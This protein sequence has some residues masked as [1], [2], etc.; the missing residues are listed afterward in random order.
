MLVILRRSLQTIFFLFLVYVIWVTKDP[1]DFFVN[2]SYYFKLDPFVMFITSIAERLVL[3]GIALALL[4]IV[5]TAIFGRFFCGWFCPL[6]AVMDFWAWILKAFKFRKFREG[7]PSKSV[8]VK[9]VILGVV[10][11]FSFIGIQIA[12]ALD[13]IAVFVRTFSFDF[14]PWVNSLVNAAFA[15]SMV[16]LGYPAWLDSAFNWLDQTILSAKVPVFP[17]SFAILALFVFILATVLIKRRF[18]C[19]YVCPLGGLLAVFAKLA[20]YKRVVRSCRENC[21]LCSQVCRM[22]AITESNTYI[23]QECILCM[24]CTRLCPNQDSSFSFRPAEA[25]VEGP[26]PDKMS[27]ISRFDFLV[28]IT[29]IMLLLTGFSKKQ[30]EKNDMPFRTKPVVRPPGALD[31]PEFVKRCIRCGNCMKVCITNVLQ[32]CVFESGL[33]GI[34]TPRLDMNI[35]YCENRCNLCTRVCP[36]GAIKKL[37]VEDKVV[38]RLGTAYIDHNIC[39]PWSKGENCLVCEE[40]C[41]VPSKA[42]KVIKENRAGKDVMLP[43]IDADLCIGCGICQHT[44]PTRPKRAVTVIP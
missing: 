23:K 13:P 33:D 16:L 43:I 1:L 22:N 21:S 44:C 24:D 29:G 41:P 9:Y 15:K 11:I 3:P 8:N 30:E 26:A 7:E 4:T 6:G 42:I 19:R 39:V 27:G 36:T 28:W 38:Y 32:P 34:W 20:P 40:H 25:A 10:F 35:G 14:H 2:P 37:E 18:W 17:H 31:E 5:I 12:W